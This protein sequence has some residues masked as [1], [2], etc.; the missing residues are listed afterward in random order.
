MVT[1]WN[2]PLVLRSES[3]VRTIGGGRILNPVATHIKKPDDADCTLA[4]E[5]ESNDPTRRTAAVLYF[6]GVQD[7]PSAR[8]WQTTGS[9]DA[10]VVQRLID[11]DDLVEIELSP[12]RSLRVHRLSLESLC[13]QIESVLKHCH[14]AEPLRLA[15]PLTKLTDAFRHLDD[16]QLLK[17]AIKILRQQRRI[18]VSDSGI[19]LDGY[20]PKLSANQR[21]LLTHI[22]QQFAK[23][24][25]ASPT[26]AQLQSAAA[27][28]KE[29]V[30]KLLELAAASGDLVAISAEYYLHRD[31]LAAVKQTCQDAFTAGQGVTLSEIRELL[32]TTRKYAV[33]LCEYFDTTNFTRRD[34]DLRY[35]TET[36]RKNPGTA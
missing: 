30:P 28:N 14:T 16:D 34:G 1:T 8:L 7:V 17:R 32:G 15:I 2:Q 24:G 9:R 31:V 12:T 22:V 11:S 5:L 6:A 29:M 20:G 13:T 3:P 36:P 10:E 35:L 4:E 33:P 27:N 23:S 26:I 19:A 18:V 25:L 21:K